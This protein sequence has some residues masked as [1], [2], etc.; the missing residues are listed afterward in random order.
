[1]TSLLCSHLL[2]VPRCSRGDVRESPSCLK[3]QSRLIIHTQEGD[4]AR[5]YTCIY[6]LLQ[7]RVT[8]LRKQLPE[9]RGRELYYSDQ[10]VWF[11]L[12]PLVLMQHWVAMHLCT[13]VS[14]WHE[15]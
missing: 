5:E 7:R 4:K 15:M 14:R 13:I 12:P 2:S 10:H 1:M 9:D 3:L 6:N 8:L 11:L